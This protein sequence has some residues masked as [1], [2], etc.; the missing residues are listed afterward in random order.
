MTG[1]EADS[2]ARETGADSVIYQTIPN[3]VKSI[4]LPKGDLCLACLNGDYPTKCGK[5]MCRKAVENASK[6][7]CKRTYE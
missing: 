2:L 6:K 5:E 7:A 3:L 4:G 1:D